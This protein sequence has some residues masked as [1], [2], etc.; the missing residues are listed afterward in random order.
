MS[1][2]NPPFLA[3]WCVLQRPARAG[4][5]LFLYFFIFFKTIWKN[6][7]KNGIYTDEDILPQF[8]SGRRIVMEERKPSLDKQIADAAK[9]AAEQP[10]PKPKP[11]P[12]D[13]RQIIL[14]R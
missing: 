1:A 8:V 2:E 13:V 4:V 7:A 10:A 12:P 6:V 11:T 14:Q 3:V 5:G 9:R